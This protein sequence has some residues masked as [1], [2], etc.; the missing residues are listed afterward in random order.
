MNF[1]FL[2]ALAWISPSVKADAPPIEN[3]KIPDGYQLSL[4][5]YPVEGARS[6][7]IGESGTVFV[8][9]RDEKVYALLPDRNGDG[10]SDGI[11]V[12]AKSLNSPNGVAY[13]SGNLYI[14]EINRIRVLRNIE[15]KLDKP[16]KLEDWGPRFPSETHHG[17]KFIAFGP[18]GWLYVPVGA[19]CNVCLRE[20]QLYAAILKVSPDGKSRELVAQGVRNTVGFDWHP[21]TKELWFTDNGR[22]WMGDNIPPCELNRVTTEKPHYGFPHCHGKSVSD[23][24]FGKDKPCSSFVAPEHEFPAHSA[25]LG[26]RFLKRQKDGGLKNSILVAEHGS[27]NRTDP[28]GYQVTRLTIANNKITGSEAFITGFRKGSR[29]WG[30]P[31]DLLELSDGSVLISDDQAGAVYK[32]E[33]KAK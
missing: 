25:P 21:D 10:K 20:P 30:R 29:A 23:P 5:A 26:M 6:L 24:E 7:T 4:W 11:K 15:R 22:D 28:I 12:I 19:P 14:A 8:G 17:W 3:L 9:T 32:L 16:G 1:L 33:R 2:L 13:K 27:W 18:D 31:V